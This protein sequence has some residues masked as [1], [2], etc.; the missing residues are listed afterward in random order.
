MLFYFDKASLKLGIYYNG[1]FSGVDGDGAFYK[2]LELLSIYT[3][4]SSNL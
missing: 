2:K 1:F 3:T 4:S